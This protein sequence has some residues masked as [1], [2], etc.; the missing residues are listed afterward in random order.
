LTLTSC[1]SVAD[2]E[3]LC[4]R[5]QRVNEMIYDPFPSERFT[6]QSRYVR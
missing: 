3:L 5:T 1:A 4:D 2:V 6:A